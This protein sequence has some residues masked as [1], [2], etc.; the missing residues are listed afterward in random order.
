[1]ENFRAQY[2]N[3]EINQ[4]ISGIHF[5]FLVHVIVLFGL[6]LRFVNLF[7]CLPSVDF[8]LFW[9]FRS[10]G[11]RRI[12]KISFTSS[13][14]N[15]QSLALWNCRIF[16]PFFFFLMNKN[17]SYINNKSP[18]HFCKHFP[19]RP[20][21]ALLL[22]DACPDG[23]RWTHLYLG[24]PRC[25]PRCVPFCKQETRPFVCVCTC[26]CVCM[27][28]EQMFARLERQNNT[29]A[30]RICGKIKQSKLSWTFLLSQK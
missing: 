1:M 16:S 2:S 25:L 17:H 5:H 26:V 22:G 24:I 10:R 7:F 18:S 15:S 13:I 6:V 29:F 9:F 8:H 27:D 21:R 12:R 28:W 19:S 30:P 4:L 14:E 11:C 3:I 23:E 20:A